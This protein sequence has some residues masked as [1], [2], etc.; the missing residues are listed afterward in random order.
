MSG[1]C[2]YCDKTSVVT[3]NTHAGCADHIDDAMAAAFRPV[4]Q[5][6]TAVTGQ[7][8]HVTEEATP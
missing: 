2:D 7:W 3:V 5:A 8:R 1:A 6:V 4:K